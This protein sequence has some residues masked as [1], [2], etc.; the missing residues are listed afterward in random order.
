M[1]LEKFILLKDKNLEKNK[2]VRSVIRS[3][4]LP[5]KGYI[6]VNIIHK[7]VTKMVLQD[8]FIFWKFSIIN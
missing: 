1:L 8:S 5:G 6:F 2:K 7:G 4:V 3:T